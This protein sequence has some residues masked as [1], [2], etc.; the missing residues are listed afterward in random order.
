MYCKLLDDIGEREIMLESPKKRINEKKAEDK[1][2]VIL[3]G[4]KE[5]KDTLVDIEMEEDSHEEVVVQ[6]NEHVVGML[7]FN[8]G[9]NLY[10]IL[11]REE[12]KETIARG[13]GKC[14]LETSRNDFIIYY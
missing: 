6:P 10:H 4:K 2:E 12:K 5:E 9:H 8:G 3:S 7:L 14:I 11:S 13:N 1:K